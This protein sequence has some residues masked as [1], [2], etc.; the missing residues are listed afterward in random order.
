MDLNGVQLTI[1]Q[2]N[3]HMGGGG[4]ADSIRPFNSVILKDMDLKFNILEQLL[5]VFSKL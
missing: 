2:E 4:G 3:A 1:F 5:I